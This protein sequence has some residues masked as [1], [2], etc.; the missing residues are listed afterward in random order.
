MKSVILLLAIAAFAS[1]GFP[2]E[3][4][5]QMVR[6]QLIRIDTVYRYPL[7]EQ[8]LT[9]KDNENQEYVSFAPINS[10]YTLGTRMIVMRTR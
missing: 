7:E 5:V 8:Q 1:C 2:R 3:I 6:A 10:S 4:Q 9:W